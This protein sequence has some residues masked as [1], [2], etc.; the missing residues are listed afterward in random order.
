[1]NNKTLETKTTADM[2]CKIDEMAC[3]GLSS[4][5]LFVQQG[6]SNGFTAL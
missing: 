4:V 3:V 5:I 6:V 1:V 2:L